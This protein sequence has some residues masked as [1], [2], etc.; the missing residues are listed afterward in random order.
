MKTYRNERP[1]WCPHVDCAYLQRA[2]DAL[3]CGRLAKPEPHDGAMNTH[4]VCF[5]G[6]AEN[7]GP[8]DLQVY[9]GDLFWLRRGLDAIESDM[10]SW[11]G[12]R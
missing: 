5:N 12:K 11:N 8:L 1:S 6:V 4:R 10:K 9:D 3:C 2:M 7:G